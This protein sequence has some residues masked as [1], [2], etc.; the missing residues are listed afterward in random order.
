MSLNLPSIETQLSHDGIKFHKGEVVPV[1]NPE[2]G[3]LENSAELED[4]FYKSLLH[5]LILYQKYNLY[6]L[7]R[8]QS[9][10]NPTLL[11]L[12]HFHQAVEKAI[13]EGKREALLCMATGTQT[14]L[15]MVSHS[16]QTKMVHDTFQTFSCN[17]FL[18]LLFL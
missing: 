5:R 16:W 17:I 10:H 14:A 4:E 8:L 1:Y 7:H 3:E 13:A 11:V 18:G 15:Y 2:T 9:N 6:V 12:Y